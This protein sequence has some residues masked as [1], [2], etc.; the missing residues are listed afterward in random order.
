[1]STIFSLNISFTG[2]TNKIFLLSKSI[3]E[4]KI[5]PSLKINLENVGITEY[6]VADQKMI[7][8]VLDCVQDYL[9]LMKDI[10]DFPKIADLLRKQ[11][12]KIRIDS[13]NGVMGPY[14]QRIFVTELGCSQ[15]S[16]VNSTPLP[17]FGG[18]I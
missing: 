5:C 18:K 12:F 11:D 8:E 10:F 4:Y 15:N 2:I 13:M 3:K 9:D 17:D 6:N 7:V 14:A 16:V 1:M